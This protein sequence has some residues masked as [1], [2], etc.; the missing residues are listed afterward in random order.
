MTVTVCAGD[1]GYT[2]AGDPA[3]SSVYVMKSVD[4]TTTV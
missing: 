1:A 4:A 2:P 3:G